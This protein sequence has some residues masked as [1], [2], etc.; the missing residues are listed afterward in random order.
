MYIII[1]HGS[2]QYLVIIVKPHDVS[3]ED[4]KT[5]DLSCKAYNVVV[6]SVADV[7]RY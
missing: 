1:R 5:Q 6:T 2:H 7:Q 4:L 3:N